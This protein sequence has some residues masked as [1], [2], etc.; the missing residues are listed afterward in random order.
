MNVTF[1][2]EKEYELEWLQKSLSFRND[3]ELTSI[4]YNIEANKPWYI[5]YKLKGGNYH[6]LQQ[7]SRVSF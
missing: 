2:A 3:M 7:D 5:R 6:N 1:E 4:H